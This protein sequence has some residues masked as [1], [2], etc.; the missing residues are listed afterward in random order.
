MSMRTTTP[1][2]VV[3]IVAGSLSALVAVVLLLAGGGLLWAVDS[4][5]DRDGYFGTSAHRYSTPTRAIA[6]QDIDLDDIPGDIADLRIR[7]RG[8]V[9]VGVGPRDEVRRYLAGVSHEEITDAD[10]SPFRVG[11]A[12]RDGS[13]APASP[14]AQDF[15]VASSTGGRQLDWDARKGHWS[16]V[17]MNADGSPGVDVDAEVAVKVPFLRRLAIA[18]LVGGGILALM[19]G[20][21][22]TLAARSRVATPA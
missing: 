11:Y 5:M 10:F 16:V 8:D 1:S 22:L 7:P 3:G 19:G 12:R 15:W 17:V 4:N 14:G 18:F 9:F 13:R 21:L 2:R 20:L 6:T